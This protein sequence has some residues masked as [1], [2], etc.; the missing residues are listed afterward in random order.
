MPAV[1]ERIG[2]VV[3]AFQ[4]GRAQTLQIKDLLDLE[5]ALVNTDALFVSVAFE[6]AAAGLAYRQ[7]Q[8]GAMEI[9]VPNWPAHSAQVHIGIGWAIAELALRPDAYLNQFSGV[10]QGR[11]M[12]GF[13]YYSG[14]FRRRQCIQAM[15]I[16]EGI[17]TDLL[18][19]FDQGL[20]RAMWYISKGETEPLVAMIGPFPEERKAG[21]WR[22]IGLASS[23]V[24]GLDAVGSE[25]LVGT[26]GTYRAELLCGVLLCG[27]GRQNAKTDLTDV[28]RYLDTIPIGTDTLR[29]VC[30]VIAHSQDY[31][32]AMTDVK[33][34]ISPHCP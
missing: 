5:G 16:P 7:L 27:A 1:E 19:A 20:G 8:A 33:A 10:M 17:P 25:R 18:T 31:L 12:D 2:R 6:G 32:T 22:G 23:Y 28:I 26:S 29:S 14:L 3:G 9:D 21:I 30:E 15:D 34:L 24:G 11:V 13:G 4:N